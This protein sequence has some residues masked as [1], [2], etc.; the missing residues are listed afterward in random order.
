M[1]N[2]IKTI[3]QDLKTKFPGLVRENEPL[4][5]YTTYEVGGP[6]ALFFIP[7]TI[8][9]LREA[10]EWCHGE[11]LP[12]Y[13]LGG[14]SNILVSDQG[15]EM[16]VIK[17]SKCCSE[18]YHEDEKVFAG[19][20]RMVSELVQ[21]CEDHDLD[22]LDFMSGIPG[23]VGGALRMNAGAFVG[24][25]GD[26]VIQVEALHQNGEAVTIPKSE[27]G[28]GYRQADRLKDK[29]L[30]GCWLQMDKGS[31]ERLRISRESY[32]ERRA[33]KQ[34]LEYASCGSVFKRP[35][36]NY[37]G[38]LIEKAGCKGM[39]IGGAMVST[40]HANFIVNVNKATASDIY[41][42]IQMVQ[43]KVYKEFKIW[44]ELE[45]KLIGF[46]AEE[47]AKVKSPGESAVS[48]S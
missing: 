14:G 44:L 37:A 29:I 4:R 13:I 9:Q 6:A 45:V 25:I 22:G 20:G 35:A 47:K 23:T 42:L 33:A 40:K 48:F 17:L 27:A 32:L 26:R 8:P 12:Y 2:K 16:V 31:G 24:E 34:P 21:Y 36:G 43:Q 39:K 38:T 5:L 19:A 1:E 18:L 28:F 3:G 41:Q 46:T 30:L 15:L 11:N 10:L 7:D